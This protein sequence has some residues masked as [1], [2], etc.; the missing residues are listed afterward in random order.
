VLCVV[1]GASAG[2]NGTAATPFATINA[3]LAA[4]APGDVVQVAA[5]TYRENV[6][7]G[8]GFNALLQTNLAIL[9]GFSPDFA[10]RDAGQ[11]RSVI[12]GGAKGPGVQIHLQ[13]TGKTVLDGFRIMNG[14]GL[15]T[16]AEDGNGRGGGVFA[17]IIGNGEIAITHN[18]VFGNQ[19]AGFGDEKRGGG[20]YGDAQD[21]DG[22]TP[23][24]R[25]EDNIVHSNQAG[26][27]A[28]ID[29][30]GNKAVILRNIVEANVAH[31]DHG[32]GVYVST[33]HTDVG[34]NVVRGNAIGATAGY[35]YGGGL[36]LA[37]APA[38]LHGNVFTGNYAPTN[39]SA[40]FWDEGATGTMSGD[41]LFA[42]G[43]P[44][45][46]TSGVALFVDGGAGPSVVTADHITIADHQ[47]PAAAPQGAAILVEDKSRLTVRNSIIWNNAREADTVLDATYTVQTSIST[48]QGNGNTATDPQF[49]DPAN[50]DYHLRPGSPAIGA[51]SD[52]SNL[53]AYSN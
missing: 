17:E 5:G 14:R 29:V 18:E 46:A 30:E 15:G 53:G 31:S 24:I 22:S 50:G 44:N 39:G 7:V 41:L 4:A 43:C 8:G 27:G 21:Y 23:T 25:I 10:T 34:E 3:A 37:A 38:T 28:G 36:I 12:D 35:G 40:V 51:A 20:I 47:C 13:S 26:R 16:V 52:G 19:T 45:D 32:G 11:F 33:K 6:A 1:A 42:N 49:V 9:G 48:E 2:G